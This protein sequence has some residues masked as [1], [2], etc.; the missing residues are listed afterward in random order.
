[1]QKDFP[2]LP[3]LRKGPNLA[4]VKLDTILMLGATRVVLKK[5]PEHS[6]GVLFDAYASI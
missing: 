2:K 3:D 4:H 1:L 5:M 6:A